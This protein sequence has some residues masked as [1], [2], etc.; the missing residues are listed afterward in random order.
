MSY[1]KQCIIDL[2]LF[3]IYV[4]KNCWAYII[5]TLIVSYAGAIVLEKHYLKK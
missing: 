1:E 4:L 3:T 2:L 5:A